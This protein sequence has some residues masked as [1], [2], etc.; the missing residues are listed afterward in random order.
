MIVTCVSMKIFTK[1]ILIG[2]GV[3]AVLV[4]ML[5]F[6]GFGPCGP[7][8][9]ISGFAL[10]IHMPVLGALGSADCDGVIGLILGFV[11]HALIWSL[12]AYFF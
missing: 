12:L 8:S 5:F 2:I 10:S 1:A 9:W 7:S 3:E 4:A 11:V 6:G